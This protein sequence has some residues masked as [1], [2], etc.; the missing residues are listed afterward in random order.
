MTDA[1][2]LVLYCGLEEYVAG[3]ICLKD[4]GGSG[5]GGRPTAKL[6]CGKDSVGTEGE[7]VRAVYVGIGDEGGDVRVCRRA[8]AT[9]RATVAV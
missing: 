8:R 6:E 1:N 3:V 7:V 2:E 9:I 4:G 5:S